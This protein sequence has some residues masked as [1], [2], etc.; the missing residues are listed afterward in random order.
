MTFLS[1]KNTPLVIFCLLASSIACSNESGISP[2]PAVGESGDR[3]WLGVT[4]RLS[5]WMASWQQ[6]S[7]AAK[8]FASDALNVDYAIEQSIIPAASVSVRV[9]SFTFDLEV[10]DKSEAAEQGEKA[11]NYLSMG[12]NYSGLSHNLAFELGYTQGNFDGFFSAQAG[13]GSAGA[14]SFSTRLTVQDILLIHDSGVGLGYRYLNYDLPQDV[15]LV[16][17]SNTNKVLL[18]GFEN[19][20]YTGHLAQALIRSADRMHSS[21]AIANTALSLSYDA[22]A[23]LGL[24]EAG[25]EYLAAAEKVNGKLMGAGSAFFYE[26]D[27]SLYRQLEF[28]AKRYA[29]IDVGYRASFLSAKFDADTEYALVTDFETRFNGPYIALA[30]SF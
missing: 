26:F 13:D 20:E 27:V 23:G 2:V 30:G 28:S 12:V 22:R 11:L 17:R 19:F 21:N 18:A 8:R 16:H 10:I 14:A 7:T 15:Y 1:K 25:G 24:I 5:P 4:A 6:K 9:M 3:F 29:R